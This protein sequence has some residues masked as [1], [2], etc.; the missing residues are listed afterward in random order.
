MTVSTNAKIT[1]ITVIAR[2]VSD[3]TY[4]ERHYWRESM[5]QSG[6]MH[7]VKYQMDGHLLSAEA[8]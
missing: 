4:P 7:Y 2:K 1:M 3:K 8:S 6:T 5:L